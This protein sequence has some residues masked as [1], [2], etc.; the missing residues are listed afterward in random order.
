[1]LPNSQLQES[2]RF[3]GGQSFVR[4]L[5]RKVAL[6]FEPGLVDTILAEAGDEPGNLPLVE[7]V[8][9]QLWEQRQGMRFRSVR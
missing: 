5:P 2:G 4:E 8:L 9:H 6:N 7:F 3:R 1:M